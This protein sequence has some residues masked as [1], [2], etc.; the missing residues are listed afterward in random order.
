MHM[1]HGLKWNL[2]RITEALIYLCHL[3][4]L[5]AVTLGGQMTQIASADLLLIGHR[6]AM[7]HLCAV[8]KSGIN[9]AAN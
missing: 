9:M 4:P 1:K 2:M 7:N 6:A 5:A 3:N 8:T